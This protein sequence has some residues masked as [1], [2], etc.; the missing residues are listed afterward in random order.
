M[1]K[2]TKPLNY[3]NI[4]T[5]ADD[6]DK[7]VIDFMQQRNINIYDVNQCRNIPHN[8]LTLCMMQIYNK[9]FKPHHGIFNNQNSLID[10]NNNELLTVIANKFIEWSLHFDKSMGIYQFSILTGI[11]YTTLAEWANNPELNPARSDIVKSIREYHKM[12]QINL[13]NNSPV[14]A[15]AVANNDTETGLKW[16]ANQAQQITNNTVYYLPSERTDRLNLDKLDN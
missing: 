12:E 6:I 10:Y 16:A 3:I 11:H 7:I 15:L 8:V 4:N 1:A 9:L 13:L 2:Q 5:V 14:G